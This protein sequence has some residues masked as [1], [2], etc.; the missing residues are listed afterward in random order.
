MGVLRV[1]IEPSVLDW[2]LRRTGL[3]DE[4]LRAT[5]PKVNDWRSGEERPTLNQ[6]KELAKKARNPI[7]TAPSS[8]AFWRRD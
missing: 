5:F 1:D 2:A 3:S 7:W 8:G 4:K 6:A